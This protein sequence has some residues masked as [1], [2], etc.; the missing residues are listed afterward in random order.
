[1]IRKDQRFFILDYETTGIDTD[2]DLP[3]EIGIIVADHEFNLLDTYEDLIKWPDE[4]VAKRD[5][6]IP[7]AIHKIK[8]SMIADLGL[9]PGVV[10]DNVA[11]L[12]GEHATSRKPILLSD[13][14]QFE[15]AFTKRLL[16][17]LDWPFHYCGWD[18][19]LFL[20]LAGVGDPKP[21]HRALA[22]A[23]V[24]HAA[25]LKSIGIQHALREGGV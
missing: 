1:M 19:S 20:E 2:E 10:G 5:T 21:V 15:W 23:G 14:I 22:D 3:I 25:I 13:N 18:S 24:L 11:R 17:G 12:A 4:L 9:L 7:N 6:F 16:R 8:P